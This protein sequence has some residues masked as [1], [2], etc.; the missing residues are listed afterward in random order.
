MTDKSHGFEVIFYLFQLKHK[1][2]Y[3]KIECL[4][5]RLR[6]IIQYNNNICWKNKTLARGNIKGLWIFNAALNNRRIV[7][8]ILYLKTG[9]R[10]S[11]W[12]FI[13]FE[14]HWILYLNICIFGKLW[15]RPTY[16][17]TPIIVACRHLKIS[18]WIILLM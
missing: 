3:P 15:S 7:A 5:Y 1:S 9:V 11:Q 6:P 4:F 14:L 12:D 8:L 16:V 10:I 2:T 18:K 17:E 13:I